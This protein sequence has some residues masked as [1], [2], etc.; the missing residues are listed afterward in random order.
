MGVRR[1]LSVVLALCLTLST[2][3]VA[4]QTSGREPGDGPAALGRYRI[5]NSTDA[6]TAAI[7]MSLAVFDT[8]TAP[9]VVLARADVF[10]DSLAGAVLTEGR[11]PLLFVP[12]GP[13]AALPI[14]VQSELDRVLPPPSGCDGEPDV[15]QGQLARAAVYVRSKAVAAEE[16]RHPQ[17]VPSGIGAYLR[18]TCS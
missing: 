6:V 14:S 8:D 9:Q 18:H 10:A 1:A 7:D 16:R 4:A 11:G 12:G 3:S 13:D 5:G 15:F 17:C 2:G